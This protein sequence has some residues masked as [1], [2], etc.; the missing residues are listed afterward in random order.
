MKIFHTRKQFLAFFM[1]GF[2][3]GI[4]YVNFA[5]KKYMAGPGIFSEYFLSQYS[6]GQIEPRGYLLYLLRTRAVPLAALSALSFTRAGRAAAVLFLLWTGFSGGML[7]SLAAESLGIRGSLLCLAGLFPQFLFYIPAFLMVLKY[8]LAAPRADWNRQKT[9]FV[10][11]CISIG[12][13]LEL[14]VNPVLLDLLLPL[15]WKSGS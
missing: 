6:S 12:I 10:I 1:P 9:V 13:I 14:Y 11:L 7:V 8:C 3:L 4:L 5:A 2:C 15:L